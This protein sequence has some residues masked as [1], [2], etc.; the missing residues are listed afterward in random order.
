MV[1]NCAFNYTS[2]TV[3]LI[4]C[5]FNSSAAAKAAAASKKEVEE[6]DDADADYSHSSPPWPEDHHLTAHNYDIMQLISSTYNRWTYSYMNRIFK[7]G[8]MQKRDKSNKEAQLTQRD[9]YRTPKNIEASMLN[10]KFWSIYK[11]QTDHNF[12]RTLW[13]LVRKTFVPAGV[14]QLF[15]LTAQLSIPMCVMKVLQSLEMGRGGDSSNIVYVVAIF[16]LSIINALCTHRY[17]LLSYQ[18]GILLRTA[19]TSAIY[20]KSLNL[21][22]RGRMGLTNGSITNLVASDTQKL[23]EVMWEFQ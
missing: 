6:V 18:S 15:A 2:E 21:S 20:E 23:F 14:C 17:Q 19:I 3:Q 12:R 4:M 1:Y 7:K 5:S 10:H 22:P 16:I 11:Q 13:I 9:L 8:S